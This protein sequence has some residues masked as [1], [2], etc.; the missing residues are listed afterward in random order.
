[1]NSAT[2]LAARPVEAPLTI[3]LED[4][5]DGDD[6]AALLILY[7]DA[8]GP[9][10]Q[11][12]ALR[13]LDTV[14]E[15]LEVF[16][17]PAIT[18][19]IAWEGREPVGLGLVTNDLESVPATS[20]QFFRALYPEYA[21][22]NAIFYGLA[23]MVKDTRRGLTVFSRVY[24]ELWQVPAK[25]GGVLVFD[26][27]KHNRDLFDADAVIGGIAANF[28]NSSWKIIDQQTWYAAELPESLP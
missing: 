10:D 18:K 9:L 5:V 28:P 8:I 22:R 13:H 16:E 12:A 7:V 1:M 27:C 21:E 26:A 3:T 6:A 11:V 2:A 25:V 4:V 20:P 17:N 23:V 24:M 19:I 14:P 15:I